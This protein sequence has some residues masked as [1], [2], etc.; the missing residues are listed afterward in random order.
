LRRADVRLLTLTGPGGVGKTHL[1]LHVALELHSDFADGACFVPLAPISDPGLVASTIVQALGVKETAGH[2]FAASLKDYLRDKTVLLLLD[3]F[4][5]VVAAAPLLA[6]LLATCPHVKALVTSRAALRIRGEHEY[7][8][9]P[10]M[11]PPRPPQ[12]VPQSVIR[13]ARGSELPRSPT[14]ERGSEGADDLAQYTAVALFVAR[15]QAIKPDFQLTDAD[16]QAIAEICIRLDGLPLAIELAAARV[17]L[18]PPRA[19]LARVTGAYYGQMSLTLLTGGVRD[20]PP[21]QQTMR[22]TI[23]WSYNLLDPDEQRFFRR[24]AVFAG[25]CTLAAADAVCNALGDLGA[26]VLGLMGSLVDK[27][28]VR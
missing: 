27:S 15:A 17:K 6:D 18:L 11:V 9:P 16:A 21:R 5:Q 3:N 8:V 1:G 23:D 19:L 10:L 4:E 22:S 24:L 7:A 12:P 13:Q 28:L 25:G 2:Q 26:N 14:W 20:L